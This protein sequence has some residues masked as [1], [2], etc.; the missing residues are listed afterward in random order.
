MLIF[1]S[2]I[3]ESAVAVPS[4]KT[5]I[6]KNVFQATWGEEKNLSKYAILSSEYLFEKPSLT[7][8]DHNWVSFSVTGVAL[9]HIAM[10]FGINE[11][12]GASAARVWAIF[13]SVFKFSLI[14]NNSFSNESLNFRILVF[15]QV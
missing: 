5:Q 9:V 4:M 10:K 8:S 7:N 1:E 14:A 3:Q 6:S 12:H 2:N 11:T 13:H 15:D